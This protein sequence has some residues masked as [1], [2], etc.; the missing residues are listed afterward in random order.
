M[1]SN[2]P[3]SDPEK[4]RQLRLP[5]MKNIKNK[6][7]LEIVQLLEDI[8]DDTDHIVELLAD[9]DENPTEEVRQNIIFWGEQMAYNHKYILAVKMF[10]LVRHCHSREILVKAAREHLKT[11]DKDMAYALYKRAGM[12]DPDDHMLFEYIIIEDYGAALDLC[13]NSETQ[14]CDWAMMIDR[15]AHKLEEAGPESKTKLISLIHDL[16]NKIVAKSHGDNLKAQ[17][18]SPEDDLDSIL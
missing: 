14:I 1:A 11:G 2:R 8:K 16:S 3:S 13:E 4:D 17:L 9:F 15:L 18:S 12:E 5:G 10:D 6:S 7:I